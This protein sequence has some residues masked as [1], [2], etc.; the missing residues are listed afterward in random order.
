MDLID[1]HPPPVY[2]P[3]AAAAPQTTVA[4]PAPP[5]SPASFASPAPPQ[6]A[7]H[8]IDSHPTNIS[9]P[10]TSESHILPSNGQ[11]CG[12]QNNQNVDEDLTCLIPT[13]LI[14]VDNSLHGHL[15][16]G[17]FSTVRKGIL[18]TVPVAVKRL[19]YQ[20]SLAGEVSDLKREVAVLKTLKAHPNVIAFYGLV[21]HPGDYALILEY[22]QNGSLWSYMITNPTP[23]PSWP[24]LCKIAAGVAMGMAHLHANGVL[25]CDL[26]GGNILLTEHLDAK[27][28]DFGLAVWR[29]SSKLY[30]RTSP[31]TLFWQAP[32]LD[33][34]DAN[35]LPKFTPACDVFSYGVTLSEILTWKGPY[36]KNPKDML[37]TGMSMDQ[38]YLRTIARGMRPNLADQIPLDVPGN[39][40]QLLDFCW[41][42]DT[43]KRPTFDAIVETLY[44]I[45]PVNSETRMSI[46]SQTSPS[47]TSVSGVTTSSETSSPSRFPVLFPPVAAPESALQRLQTFNVPPAYQTHL[48]TSQ[49]IPSSVFAAAAANIPWP[50]NTKFYQNGVAQQQPQQPQEQSSPSITSPAE[51][52]SSV[53]SGS[54]ATTLHASPSNMIVVVP[55]TGQQTDFSDNGT[56]NLHRES[57]N[58]PSPASAKGVPKNQDRRRKMWIMLAFALVGLLLLAGI[59][60]GVVF[61]ALRRNSTSESTSRGP[62][63]NAPQVVFPAIKQTFTGHTNKVGEV[64]LSPDG[65]TVFAGSEDFTVLGWDV[66][67][68]TLLHNIT[69]ESS[70]VE[71]VAVSPDG[72]TVFMSFL[73]VSGVLGFD[74]TTKTVTRNYTGHVGIVEGLTVSP[75]GR[76]VY[77]AGDDRTVLA[78]NILNGNLVRNFTGHTKW[79]GAIALSPDGSVLYA[80]S[81]DTSILAWNTATGVILRNFTGQTGIIGDV[82]V[83]PDGTTLFAGS[84]DTNVLAWEATT[85]KILR[86]FQGHSSQVEG[87]AVSPDSRVLYAGS[88]DATVLGW[89]IASGDVICRFTGH[90]GS[91]GGGGVTVSRDGM[92]VYSGAHDGTVFSWDAP[93]LP[94]IPK[95]S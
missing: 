9:S 53:V 43:S 36:G 62:S 90:K 25:H 69:V 74:L 71:G 89:D 45:T 68:G 15:G 17:A 95:V 11:L 75:D 46:I 37:G 87:I 70:A 18:G 66:T 92:T 21:D 40:I 29:N 77:A 42:H 39:M 55:P 57:I 4:A 20:P 1:S 38:W 79:V 24:I 88:A 58:K 6:T 80:G 33:P 28:T 31:G 50:P 93:I 2:P 22:A 67:T 35:N 44:H 83:S 78:W 5:R 41:A 10:P 14:T 13:S 61:G 3:L 51:H 73:D 59:V 82:T 49:F 34:S 84:G 63:A 54:D 16:R 60:L 30:V 91:I 64:I 76:T 8:L 56:T 12:D 85:G 23:I 7:Y 94:P 65:K 32:E 19:T 86:I 52:P 48:D 26:K 81:G 47:I 27:I 72:R